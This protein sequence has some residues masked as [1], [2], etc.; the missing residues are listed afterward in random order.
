[1]STIIQIWNIILL[2]PMLN[3]LVVLQHYLFNNFGVAIVVFTVLVRVV[4]YPL[5]VKQM[6]TTKAMSQLQPKLQEVQKKFKDPQRRQQET[7][8][9]YKE[10]KVS[11]MGCLGPTLI[12]FPIWIALYQA[13]IQVLAVT[14]EG[15]LSVSKHLYPWSLIHESLP[16]NNS[17][18]WMDMGR[19]DPFPVMAILTGATMWI[20]QKMTTFPSADPRQQSMSNMMLWLMPMMFA[21]WTFMFPS[22][23]ALYWVVSNVVGIAMQYRISG[24]GSLTVPWR[25][26]APAVAGAP[27]AGP[28]TAALS[29][30]AETSPAEAQGKEVG[31]G[32]YRD[33]RQVRR[34]RRRAGPDSTGPG[35]KPGPN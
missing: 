8:K 24:W 32:K 12:Q 2:Q 31:R 4:T 3:S 5:F 17:F 27:A 28:Q 15:L 34:R 19:P 10:Q 16:L 14:P 18:L 7:M 26:A 33:K 11:P 35:P 29:Q 22:G 25:R 20:Q 9:L 6:R 23:L 13:V 1:M 21:L 30:P